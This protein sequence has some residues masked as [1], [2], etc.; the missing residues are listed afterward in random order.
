MIYP[1]LNT[2]SSTRTM[3]SVFGGYDHRTVINEGDFFDMKNLSSDK[4]PIISNRRK[5][6]IFRSAIPGKITGM[7]AKEHLCYTTGRYFCIADG[8]TYE[9]DTK[10]DLGLS[11]D[12]NDPKQLV[13]FGAY[14]I[15]FPDKKY[16]NLNDT[17]DW[18]VLDATVTI[19][20][21]T[22]SVSSKNVTYIL[23][24]AEGTAF[25][26]SN[27]EVGSFDPDS[28][29]ENPDTT[30]YYY[31]YISKQFYQYYANKWRTIDTYLL[32]NTN[33]TDFFE[34][35]LQITISGAMSDIVFNESKPIILSGGYGKMLVKG[36][37]PFTR[38]GLEEGIIQNPLNQTSQVTFSVQDAAT[39][40][41]AD[42]NRITIDGSGSTFPDAAVVGK[43]FLYTE[44]AYSELYKG[45]GKEWIKQTPYIQ[46]PAKNIYST[47][48]KGDIVSIKGADYIGV[49]D[50]IIGANGEEKKIMSISANGIVIEGLAYTNY[51]QIGI[52]VVGGVAMLNGSITVQRKIPT[53]FDFVIES[54][55]RLWGC[56]YG[57]VDGKMVNEIYASKL[58]DFKSWHSFNGTSQDS[59]SVSVGSDGAFTGAVSYLGSPLFFKEDRIYR[60]YGNYPSNY[61]VQT[62]ECRGVE[63]GSSKSI[64]IINEVLFY[65][66][67]SGIC[68]YDGSLPSLVSAQL[69]DI[70]YK[71]AIGGAV[72]NKYYV[73][74]ETLDNQ[75]RIARV[76]FVYDSQKGL[77]HKEDENDIQ[78]AFATFKN[79]LYCGAP[80]VGNTM[81]LVAVKGSVGTTEGAQIKWMAESGVMGIELPDKKYIS[82]IDI[83][84]SLEVGHSARFFIEYDSSGVWEPLF[85]MSGTPLGSFGV[86]I[87]PNRCDHFRIRIEGSGEVRIFS[88]CKTI[89]QGGE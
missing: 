52:D 53:D 46:I 28:I 40:C 86:P 42:G 51:N 31:N 89:E 45:D 44:S 87:M 10:I 21:I 32:I 57:L 81:K 14:V 37:F 84:M 58:G 72:D 3:T 62:T 34:K 67:R 76:L 4:Y 35:G 69:G 83:R 68:T 23:C 33:T 88:I 43:Y 38:G 82:K 30:K 17:N 19:A 73:H 18:G 49:S 79:E 61:Q 64:A 39:L 25:S 56:K 85:Y 5:R 48:D 7:I 55:N 8:E 24:N 50:A 11:D 9:S 16:I 63:E 54:N 71:N 78:T 36:N 13:S 60:I 80:D 74:M 22:K 59:Y 41:D 20:P 1:K 77:W 65:K 27:T 70:V 2:V 47:F 75:G 29:T 12:H 6:G 15:I 26:K 66:S